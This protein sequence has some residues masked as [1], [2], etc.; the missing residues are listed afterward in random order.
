M[1]KSEQQLYITQLARKEK[2]E[3]AFLAIQNYWEMH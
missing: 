1:D 2:D 3:E